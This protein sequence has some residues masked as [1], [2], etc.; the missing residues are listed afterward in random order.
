[1]VRSSRSAY[2]AG[3]A[4][5]APAFYE[6]NENAVMAERVRERLG[7]CPPS[8]SQP[9]RSSRRCRTSCRS[10]AYPRGSALEKKLTDAIPEPP[11]DT[12]I[13]CGTLSWS[14]GTCIGLDQCAPWS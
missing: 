6:Q 3:E 11:P 7:E 8:A 2:P 9:R 5:Q 4:P 10:T 13:T 12:C 1:M 14:G